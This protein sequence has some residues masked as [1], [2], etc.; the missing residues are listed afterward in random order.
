MAN[1]GLIKPLHGL[2]GMAAF[3]VLVG[4][5]T[6]LLP[7]APSLGVVLFFLL[8]GFL[9]GRLYLQRDFNAAEVKAYVSARVARV[10]PLFAL[11]VLVAGVISY[12]MPTAPFGFQ[13]SD[14]VP[15]LLLFGS[16]STIWTISVEFQFYALFIVIWFV[17]ARIPARDALLAGAVIVFSIAAVV[18]AEAGRISLIRYLHLFTGGLLLSVLL[19]HPASDTARRASAI[20]FPVLLAGYGAA[21]LLVR[22]FYQLDLIY[23]DLISCALC[24]AL[25]YVAVAAPSSWPARLLSLPPLVWMGEISFGVYLIHR[26]VQWGLTQAMPGLSGIGAFALVVL[27]TLGLSSLTFLYYEKPARRALRKAGDAI[28]IRGPFLQAEVR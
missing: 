20:A 2:R 7:T 5:S 9:M 4:H 22:Q 23:A 11:I 26:I 3:T 6:T 27:L 12:L 17:Y 18:F 15:H 25:I 16:A 10:Y 1:T 21:F 19:K 24:A 8:S 14:I 28:R 13:P